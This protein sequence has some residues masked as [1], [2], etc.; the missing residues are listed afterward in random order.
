MPTRSLDDIPVYTQTTLVYLAV[1]NNQAQRNN[2]LEKGESTSFPKRF[3]REYRMVKNHFGE[4]NVELA[5]EN[6]NL[7]LKFDFE[8]MSDDTVCPLLRLIR[9]EQ[10]EFALD[11][12]YIPPSLF[13]SANEQLLNLLRRINELLISRQQKFVC[14]KTCSS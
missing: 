9:N 13:I 5:V 14:T 4:D 11:T 8:D 7:Q 1:P 2:L 3:V 10:G 6:L 12:D